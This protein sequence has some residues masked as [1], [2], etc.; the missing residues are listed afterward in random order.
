MCHEKPLE[1]VVKEMLKLKRNAKDGKPNGI[2]S[3]TIEK[4][5]SNSKTYLG[6]FYV[7]SFKKILLKAK[8]F[9]LVFYCQFHWFCVYSTKKTFEIFDPIGFLTKKKCFGRNF[10]DFLRAHMKN[11]VVYANP[12]IQSDKSF[13]CGLYVIFFIKM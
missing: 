5:L 1:Q 7:D 3:I 8:N 4:L 12:R 13:L 6:N 9:S 2:S 11:K 10:L